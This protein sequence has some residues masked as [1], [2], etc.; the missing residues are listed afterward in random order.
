MRYEKYKVKKGVVNKYKFFL[1]DLKD[2]SNWVE[3][4]TS[5]VQSEK[6]DWEDGINQ[7]MNVLKS[8]KI[9]IVVMRMH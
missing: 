3:E 9:F 2:T 6:C 1:L 4:F 8:F 5:E 7:H